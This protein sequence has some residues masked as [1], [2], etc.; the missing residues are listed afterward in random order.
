MSATIEAKAEGRRTIKMM[1]GTLVSAIRDYGMSPPYQLPPGKFH[2][3][4]GVGKGPRNRAGWAIAF[5]GGNGG[6]FGDWSTGNQVLWCK[7]E[8]VFGRD[9]RPAFTKQAAEAYLRQDH[10]LKTLQMEKAFQLYEGAGPA[11]PQHPYLKKKGVHAAD[12]VR[13][14]GSRLLIPLLNPSLSFLGLQTVSATGEKFFSIGATVKGA[15]FPLYSTGDESVVAICEGYATGATIWAATGWETAVAFSAGNLVP[16]AE[17]IRSRNPAVRIVICADNDHRSEAAGKANAGLIAGRA[18]SQ[19]ARAFLAAPPSSG[20]TDW[21][22]YAQQHGVA[23]VGHILL[24]VV[25]SAQ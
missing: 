20:G 1:G 5:H 25:G 8:D 19:A 12:G 23:A 6:L 21:N 3:F 2:R 10:E 15:Y 22:D 13:Q 4:A 11:D 17:S 24:G 18:A 14:T 16:V 7:S 9:Q